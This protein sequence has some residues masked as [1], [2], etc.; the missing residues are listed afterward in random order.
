MQCAMDA[1]ASFQSM[2]LGIDLDKTELPLSLLVRLKEGTAAQ[3]CDRLLA[4]PGGEQAQVAPTED[5]VPYVTLRIP[6]QLAM[7]ADWLEFWETA[8]STVELS[9]PVD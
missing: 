9:L 3:F 7:S 6:A 1:P 4:M 8:A 5:A 2:L